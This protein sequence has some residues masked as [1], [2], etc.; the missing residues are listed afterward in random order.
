MLSVKSGRHHPDGMFWLRRPIA[1]HREMAGKLPL[2]ST[3]ATLASL[4]SLDPATVKKQFV[5]PGIDDLDS[6]GGTTMP[7]ASESA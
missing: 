7:T 2:R 5:Y 4:A 1:K 3:T 6:V